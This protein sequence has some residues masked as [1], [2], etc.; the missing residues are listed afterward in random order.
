MIRLHC[1][2][3]NQAGACKFC[4]AKAN[5][6]RERR[7]ALA[8]KIKNGASKEKKTDT[9]KEISLYIVEVKKMHLYNLITRGTATVT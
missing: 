5:A 8:S 9:G 6:V 2:M 1:A 7:M 4:V 3:A